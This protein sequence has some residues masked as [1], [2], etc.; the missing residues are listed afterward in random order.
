MPLATV[1]AGWMKVTGDTT[2]LG[3]MFQFGDLP[4]SQLDG[5]AAVTQ[6]ARQFRFTRVF[7]GPASFRG[8]DATTLLSIANP[9]SGPIVLSLN[10]LGMRPGQLL[11][12]QQ[13]LAIPAGGVYYGT[14][15]QLFNPGQPVGGGWIDVQ[16]LAGEGAVGFELIRFPVP[17]TVVG[18]NA[19][20]GAAPNQSYSAQLVVN[21]QYFT[22]IRLINTSTMAR[23]MVLHA[24]DPTGRD[25]ATP[26]Q[27][28]LGVGESVQEEA[29]QLFGPSI[30]DASL[31]VDADG[32]GIIGDVIFGDPGRLNFAAASPLQSQR[33][34]QAVFSH[35]ANGLNYF[36]GIALLNP[37]PQAATVTLDVFSKTGTKTGS[38]TVRLAPGERLSR[39]LVDPLLVPASAGQLGGFIM[40]SSTLPV[41]GQ[42]LFGDTAMVFLSAVPPQIIK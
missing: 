6:P 7:E 12:P 1:Q 37:N 33:F 18:L 10:L 3:C 21:A 15:A 28:S 19:V 40:L 29:E 2:Q 30:T 22:N 36:T 26:A 24:L 38:N 32:P 25:A 42:E 8:Q 11:A 34:S 35:V 13:I 14:A 41:V 17:G 5:A 39:L 20:S 4:G 16:V 9:T 31:R 23:T 27:I